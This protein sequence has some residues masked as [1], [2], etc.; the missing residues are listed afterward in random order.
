MLGLADETVRAALTPLGGFAL[1][2]DIT[3]RRDAD[4][5]TRDMANRLDKLLVRKQ[6]KVRG[7]DLRASAETPPAR[8]R[9]CARYYRPF[10]DFESGRAEGRDFEV[11]ARSLQIFHLPTWEV[12]P[13]IRIDENW[14]EFS[15]SVLRTMGVELASDESVIERDEDDEDNMEGAAT[16]T[17]P[18][19]A[20]APTTSASTAQ[21]S[22]RRKG[23]ERA[24][25]AH[26]RR[27]GP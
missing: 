11:C 14:T 7:K 10:E 17:A 16:P 13:K 15:Q 18:A 4:Y 25:K 22:R 1:N 24:G 3:F 27:N 20:D 19:E 21:A 6:F 26:A 5:D 12:A 23:R 9:A 2:H 8:R